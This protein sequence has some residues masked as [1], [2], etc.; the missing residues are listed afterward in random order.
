MEDYLEAIWV[1]GLEKKSVRVK[2]VCKFLQVKTSSV[3]NAIKV[4]SGM[5]LV[6]QEP[7]GYIE[8]TQ[9]GIPTA[10][11][12]YKKHKTLYRFLHEILGIDA[13]RAEDDACKMEHAI[14]A[15]TLERIVEFMKFIEHCPRTGPSW[16]AYFNTRH[17]E[18]VTPEECLSHMRDFKDEFSSKL[19]KMEPKK[20]SRRR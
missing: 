20:R 7:Y 19:Q 13:K 17:G 15:Q 16:L 9:K 2:D 6:Q 11:K 5:Q 14:S 12:I 18:T 3:A 8:L 4:L 1:L 10:K